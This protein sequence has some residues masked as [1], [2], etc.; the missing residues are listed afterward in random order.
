MIEVF[1]VFPGLFFLAPFAATLLRIAAGYTF[2]YMANSL[3]QDRHEIARIHLPIIGH[4]GEGLVWLTAILVGI[5]GCM[6]AVGL[7]TQVAAIFGMLFVIKHW[8][9]LHW[10]R[11]AAGLSRGTL[12]LLFVVCFSLLITGAGAFAFDLPL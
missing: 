6:L 1:S 12:A 2:L 10:Y 7:Y 4:V 11:S 8:F 5:I 3:I 9:W